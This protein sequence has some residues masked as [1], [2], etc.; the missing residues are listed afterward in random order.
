MKNKSM[1]SQ[2]LNLRV[3]FSYIN[4]KIQFKKKQKG[5]KAA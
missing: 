5:V 1:G 4:I 3:F 2:I